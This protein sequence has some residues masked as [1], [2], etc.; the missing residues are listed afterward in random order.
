MGNCR[1]DC[2]RECGSLE[3]AYGFIPCAVQAKTS[4]NVS[5]QPKRC[6][7]NDQDEVSGSC[8]VS[9]GR[10]RS[11]SGLARSGYIK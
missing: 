8:S 3:E 9:C 1:V 6:Y 4:G 2:L 10:S 7:R 11:R 5:V